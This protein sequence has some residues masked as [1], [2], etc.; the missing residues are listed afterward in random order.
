MKALTLTPEWAFAVCYLDK[1]IEN[2]T[3]NAPI[4]I[5][6][7][8][9]VIH[10]GKTVGGHQK[11]VIEAID[12][13]VECAKTDGWTST[14]AID[15]S[16]HARRANTYRLEKDGRVVMFGEELLSKGGI[17]AIVTVKGSFEPK[18]KE[19]PPWGMEGNKHWYLDNVCVL[20]EM[21]EA[22]GYQGL[23]N[24]S[25][26]KLRAV[27]LQI[28][29]DKVKFSGFVESKDP[30]LCESC[31]GLPTRRDRGKLTYTG[32]KFLCSNCCLP[33][34]EEE[35][36]IVRNRMHAASMVGSAIAY[37]L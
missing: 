22:R 33:S 23:W 35:E 16:N 8:R 5:I 31:N 27:A 4:K 36:K 3:W 1:K 14:V 9:L 21:V 10:A 11:K 18:R 15:R 26:E 12:D 32:G 6:N 17:V 28:G 2:R 25:D 19:M 7:Q 34:E 30:I 24:V 13:V 37:I 29:E 20:D